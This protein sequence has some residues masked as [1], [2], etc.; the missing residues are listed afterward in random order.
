[1]A[2]DTTVK[3]IWNMDEA[4]LKSLNYYMLSCEAALHNWDLKSTHQFLQSIKLV[5]FPM[6]KDKE[7]TDLD[8]ELKELEA[9]KRDV[10]NA[11]TEHKFKENS[12]KY[13]NKASDIYLQ[14]GTL[15]V[16]HGL[17]FR[18]GEDAQYA[19]LRR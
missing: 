7:R 5:V 15:I 13:H 9:I 3:S 12:I 1:M 16:K 19:A 8:K 17:I 2:L 14:F 4:R 10:D 18:K 6:F 11:I